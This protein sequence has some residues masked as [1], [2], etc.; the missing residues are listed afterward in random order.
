[1][2]ASRVIG[3]LLSAIAF[4][5]RPT[6]VFVVN[7]AT[8]LFV[9][10]ALLVVRFDGRPHGAVTATPLHRLIGGFRAA[11]DDQVMRRA[12]V[13]V[14]LFSL[15]SL[16]YIY[17]MKGFARANLHLSAD[18][19]GLLFSSFGLGAAIGAV[20]VGTALSQIRRTTVTRIGLGGFAISL[21]AFSLLHTTAPAYPVVAITG[22]FYFLVITALSTALQEEVADDVRGRVMGLWMMGWAGLVPV[23]SL[24]AGLVIDQIGYTPV[25]LFGAVISL[26]LV[27]Y[28]NLERPMRVTG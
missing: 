10:V 2:N 8:Y 3:P 27:A 15:C 26:A 18:R 17:Q 4:L 11:R 21:A 5:H 9:I 13:T 19:F 28:A 6:N 12:L 24:L 14:S 1:M 16:A 25:M 20:A 7:A 23:G 22:F